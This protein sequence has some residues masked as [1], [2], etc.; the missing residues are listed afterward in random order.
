MKL[1][2]VRARQG[3]L[4]VRAGFTVF[5]RQPLA[6]SALFA[7]FGLGVFVLLQLPLIGPVVA[8]SLM[9]VATVAF[10][11]ATREVL[12]GRI[13][14]PKL[15]L[16]PLRSP[17]HRGRLLQ[18][19]AAYAAAA[20][21]IV[22]LAHLLDGGRF[23][24]AVEAIAANETTTEAALQDPLLPWSVLLRLGLM[25]LLSLAF[26]HA[27]ALVC[28]GR[29]PVGQAL[30]ASTI[31]CWRS[32]GAFMVYGLTWFGLTMLFVTLLQVVAAL[33]GLEQV[34]GMAALPIT[35]LVSTIF[36][37]SLYFS[38]VDSFEFDSSE[39]TPAA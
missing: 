20:V 7:L 5:F 19:G 11:L 4:W 35:L 17:L 8:L 34:V 33:L 23:A 32:R 29:M 26:W 38:F 3:V 28:W 27:P 2:T 36:Y 6:F 10:L 39:E 24:A 30:F 21:A 16:L 31:A 13:A 18:L 25:A 1:K 15:M 9:P 12:A 14:G 22:L 37:A